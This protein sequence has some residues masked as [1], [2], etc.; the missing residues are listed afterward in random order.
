MCP[1]R[2]QQRRSYLFPLQRSVLFSVVLRSSSPPL[3][4]PSCSYYRV[5]NCVCREGY[6]ACPRGAFGKDPIAMNLFGILLRV[7]IR[8]GS[9]RRKGDEQRKFTLSFILPPCY[10]ACVTSDQLLSSLYHNP[11]VP[12][13]MHITEH[14]GC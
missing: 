13:K 12:S 3:C 11:P 10:E 6:T 1:M 9:V 4:V 5:P 8:A 7:S 14:T 2:F